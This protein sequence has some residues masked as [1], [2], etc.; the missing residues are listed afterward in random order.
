MTYVPGVLMV[1]VKVRLF[2]AGLRNPWVTAIREGADWH[3]PGSANAILEVTYTYMY[4]Y[5]YGVVQYII[6]EFYK[7]LVHM[8]RLETI[9]T[10]RIK[11][12]YQQTAYTKTCIRRMTAR[13]ALMHILLYNT[14]RESLLK[15]CLQWHSINDCC[16]SL[17][18]RRCNTL[19]NIWTC[20]KQT[21]ERSCLVHKRSIPQKKQQYSTAVSTPNTD[22]V[23]KM[24]YFE[25]YTAQT[26]LDL[27]HA[28][29]SLCQDCNIKTM[30]RWNKTPRFAADHLS[31]YL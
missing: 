8:W 21:K 5:I 19:Q 2:P 31:R 28:K 15:G 30:T 27:A 17:N 29:W 11:P 26:S 23:N 18:T 12:Q 7:Q 13:R 16:S 14:Y 9:I 20:H 25:W 24:T 22:E 4:I 10:Y 3:R 6:R 1:A